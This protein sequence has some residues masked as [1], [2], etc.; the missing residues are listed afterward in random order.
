MSH[1]IRTIWSPTSFFQILTF[2]ILKQ[3]WR[4]LAHLSYT[5]YDRGFYILGWLGNCTSWTIIFMLGWLG[6]CTSWTIIFMLGWLCMAIGWTRTNILGWL[7]WKDVSD[8]F[9]SKTIFASLTKQSLKKEST[10]ILV[11]MF[12]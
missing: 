5:T 10:S 2:I 3:N 8:G 12:I 11:A 6:N 4:F 9:I 7:G 1:R